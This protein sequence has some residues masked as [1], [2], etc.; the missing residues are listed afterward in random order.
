MP[1]ESQVVKVL[2]DGKTMQ[3]NLATF[4]DYGWCRDN[5][6]DFRGNVI[7]VINASRYEE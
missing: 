1:A 3:F 7:P 6:Q 5:T 2:I 4:T